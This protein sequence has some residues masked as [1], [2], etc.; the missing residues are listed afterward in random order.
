MNSEN[1]EAVANEACFSTNQAV[2]LILIQVKFQAEQIF[3]DFT[4]NLQT[5]D[6][7]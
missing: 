2:N 4:F 5:A 6:Y 3:M 7:S 1:I